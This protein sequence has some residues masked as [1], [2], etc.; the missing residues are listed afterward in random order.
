MK[1]IK[2]NLSSPEKSHLKKVG[3]KLSEL[4]NYAIDEL[5]T[6]LGVSDQR[7]KIIG[8]HLMFQSLPSIGPKFAQDLIDMGYYNLEQL[9]H[10]DGAE[11]LNEHERFVGYQ[12]DPCVEDQFRLVVHYASHPGIIKQWWDFTPERKAFRAKYGYPVDRPGSLWF[13]AEKYQSV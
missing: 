1:A 3:I 13:N 10:K 6:L 11:L 7:A 2:L 12:T 9:K 4:G 5:G 8:A